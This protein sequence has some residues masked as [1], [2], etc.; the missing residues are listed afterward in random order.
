MTLNT[1]SLPVPFYMPHKS[2]KE[3]SSDDQLSSESDKEVSSDDRLSSDDEGDVGAAHVADGEAAYDIV[4][5]DSERAETSASQD[6]STF[7]AKRKLSI[8]VCETCET[9][10]RSRA[11]PTVLPV[12][13][14]PAQ[15][16]PQQ[17]QSDVA[18]QLQAMTNHALA[19]IR[20]A[21]AMLRHGTYAALGDCEDCE[22]G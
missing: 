2:G 16:L 10:K 8:V 6:E 1:L 9:S 3:V 15:E 11:N 14:A 18:L 20:H 13:Q 19:M 4:A 5:A 22:L 17:S 12:I 21:Q 7:P